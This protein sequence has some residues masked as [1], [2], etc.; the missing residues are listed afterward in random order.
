MHL[1]F[2]NFEQWALLRQRLGRALA[3]L[4]HR[5][6]ARRVGVAGAV[7]DRD[8]L[9]IGVIDDPDVPMRLLSVRGWV[10]A[11][12]IERIAVA[13]REVHDF[14]VLHLDVTDAV[15]RRL[16]VVQQLGTLLEELEDRHVRVR[17]VGLHA[18]PVRPAD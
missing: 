14:A 17:L 15:F 7:L 8:G 16:A 9:V 2:V 11:D 13:M 6:T 3:R 10:T 4:R 5:R 1:T 12:N 18:V